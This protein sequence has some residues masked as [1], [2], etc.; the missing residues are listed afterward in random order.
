MNSRKHE[1]RVAGVFYLLMAVTA[2]VCLNN[3]PSWSMV[4]GNAAAM[5]NKIAS[6]P[7][8]YRIGI[9]SDLAAQIFF[10]FL[11]L[12]LYQLLREV[13]KK[14]AALMVA[15]VF[16]QVPMAFANML[17]GIAPLVFLSGADYLSAFDKAQLDA[18]QWHL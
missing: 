3:V 1:A 15:L 9:V 17:L 14:H 11:V 18:W 13:S 8:R 4:G 10:I 16:V 6:S 2:G 7:L 12:A 5:A